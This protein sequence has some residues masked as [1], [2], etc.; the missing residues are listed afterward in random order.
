[1]L[2]IVVDDKIPFLRGALEQNAKVLYL[3]GK[4][5]QPEHVKN[6]DALIVRTRTQCNEALLKNSSVKLITSATIGYDHIDTQWCEQNNI[7]WANAPGC[8]ANSV[9]Q[10]VAS[11]LACLSQTHAVTLEN[12]TL[13]IIGAGNIGSRLA[14]LA[15]TIGINT[16]LNDPPRAE[17]EGAAGFVSLDTLLQQADIITLHIPLERTMQND[18]FHLVNDEFLGKIKT[19]AWLINSSRGETADTQALLS[20]L[21]SRHLAGVILDVWENEP[22]INRELMELSTISTP[23]IAGY[24]ADGKANGTAICVRNISKFF[25]LGMDNWYPLQIPLPETSLI[26][27]PSTMEN[28][29]DIF[30]YL[31]LASYPIESDSQ[32]LRLHPADFEKQRETYPVRRE[33]HAWKVKTI[34]CS[35]SERSFIRELGYQIV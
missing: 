31:A 2:K 11:A 6:A 35:E 10:Y 22:R 34:S 32:R 15:K 29:E 25:N 27:F 20:H 9:V 17:K 8:N 30:R 24:S 7:L 14:G 13:G 21:K 23:H 19:G 1:M 5:I 33:P 16:L 12:K 4:Q 3:P 18:T 26:E 28:K